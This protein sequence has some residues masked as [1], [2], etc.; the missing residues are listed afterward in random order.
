MEI[1]KKLFCFLLLIPFLIGLL[2]GYFIW[3]ESN[4][5][6][7][8]KNFKETRDN[9]YTFINPLLDCEFTNDNEIEQNLN[10]LRERIENFILKSKNQKKISYA[11]VYYR[12]LNNGPWFGINEKEKFSPASLLKVLILM[13]FLKEAEQNTTIFD[14]KLILKKDNINN[15][16]LIPVQT[17]LIV[18]EEYTVNELLEQLI[19][20]S[21]NDATYTLL[22]QRETNWE[23]LDSLLLNL[24]I[25]LPQE[26][27]ENYMTVKEYAS[28]FRILYNASFLSKEMSEKALELLSRTDF[29][30]GIPAKIDPEINIAHKFG[31]REI[32]NSSQ[33]IAT[34][35]LHDCGIVY[36]P[37]NPYIICIM[38]RGKDIE[39]M[40]ETI[41][42]ISRIVYSHI[43]N[44]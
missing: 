5:Y 20:F 18:G 30:A 43:Q 24:D 9:R 25:I 41:S 17:P 16:Q 6:N 11:S 21:D 32:I 38:T 29:Q 10:V 42:E 40:T 13:A 34:Q 7:S 39:K 36:V 1:N 33:A 37:T 22:E 26:D 31:E 27:T 12:D 23:D 28:I 8:N 14:E 15:K 19:I 35:Q 2:S 44:N 3:K 4:Q